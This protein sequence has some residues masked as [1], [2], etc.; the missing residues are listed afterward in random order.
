MSDPQLDS[1]NRV[2]DGLEKTCTELE[3]AAV[4]GV[5]EQGSGITL[6]RAARAARARD[7]DTGWVALPVTWEAGWKASSL[8]S[9]ALRARRVG[10]LITVRLGADRTGATLTGNA[11]GNI[12]DT[13]VLTITDPRF[14][15]AVDWSH[16]FGSTYAWGE[17][18]LMQDGKWKIRSYVATAKLGASGT[19]VSTWI[20]AQVVCPGQPYDWS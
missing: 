12:T 6:P 4:T 10:D 19:G 18:E 9:N 8:G 14:R 16:F 15:P 7:R 20:R 5:E 13:I 1:L 17:G 2:L 11:F 3:E